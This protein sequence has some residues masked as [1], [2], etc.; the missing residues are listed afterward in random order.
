MPPHRLL[1]FLASYFP[2]PNTS[3]LK[4]HCD[5]QELRVLNEVKSLKKDLFMEIEELEPS[6]RVAR[7]TDEEVQVLFSEYRR[8][9]YSNDR[10]L[11]SSPHSNHSCEMLNILEEEI[12][13][14][15]DWMD[16][17]INPF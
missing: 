9:H 17:E 4:Q 1:P 15:Y 12:I 7:M 14:G 6:V 5:R 8:H 3:T 10:S 2:R 16:K 13:K 11:R